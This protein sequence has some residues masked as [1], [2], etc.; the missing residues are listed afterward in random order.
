MTERYNIGG[1]DWDN[2]FEYA[3]GFTRH[4]IKEVLGV[5]EGENDGPSW[6]IYGELMDGRYFFLSA[7]CDYTGWDCQAGGRSWI[8]DNL[9]DIKWLAMGDDDRE[10]FGIVDPKHGDYPE[11]N[12]YF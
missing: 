5:Q 2:A 12:F 6:I 10:R 7:G 9:E 4:D 3:N 1:Y 11:R 8:Y